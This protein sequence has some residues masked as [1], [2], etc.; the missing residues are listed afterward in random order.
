MSIT[1]INQLNNP[2]NYTILLNGKPVQSIKQRETISIPL[3]K[4]EN[5]ISF[6]YAKIPAISVK[7][8]DT[9]ILEDQF[10]FAI[11]THWGFQLIY[12]IFLYFVNSIIHAKLKIIVIPLLLLLPA[13]PYLLLPHFTIQRR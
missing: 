2:Y 6:K 7:E 11:L 12:F 4:G 1:I 9:L 13:L 8:G 5:Q 10:P 3:E